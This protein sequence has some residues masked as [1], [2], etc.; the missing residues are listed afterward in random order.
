M[1]AARSRAGSRTVVQERNISNN[2]KSRVSVQDG[3]LRSFLEKS[4]VKNAVFCCLS[5]IAIS[6]I[7]IYMIW[8]RA[9]LNKVGMWHQNKELPELN[10]FLICANVVSRKRMSAHLLLTKTTLQ[11]MQIELLQKYMPTKFLILDLCSLISLHSIIVYF[12][13][14]SMYILIAR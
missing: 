14:S 12:S 4:R 1:P 7:Y 6:I 10:I 11:S 9:T 3:S 8:F 2:N 13:C 5:V